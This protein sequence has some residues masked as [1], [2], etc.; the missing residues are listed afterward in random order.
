[1]RFLALISIAV[2]LLVGRSIPA[3]AEVQSMTVTVDGLACPFCAFGLE[4]K[5]KKVEGVEQLEIDVDAGEAILTVA[6][7]TRLGASSGAG[8]NP[9][10][11]LVPRVKEAVVEAGFTPRDLRSTVEG[12]IVH[13]DGTMRLS[14]SG[15]GEIL[16]LEEDSPISEL[17]RFAGDHPVQ[18]LGTLHT[19]PTNLRMSVDEIVSAKSTAAVCRL[20]ISGMACT[21]CAEAIQAGLEQQE[22]VK[23]ARVDLDTGIA[24]ITVEKAGIRLEILAEVVNAMEMEGMPAGTFKA[25][26][27]K[28]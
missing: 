9:T 1:M 22:G 28:E 24:E 14:V 20:K 25:T 15:T 3:Q 4:K 2:W 19:E 5:L 11:G 17:Q 21:G 23:N 13:T 27:L 12:N 8:G 26:A 18:V 7:G 10:P 16:L 6:P